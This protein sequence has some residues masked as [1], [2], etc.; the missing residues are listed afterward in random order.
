MI[1]TGD[2]LEMMRDM[3]DNSVD[4][5]VTDPPYG[6]SF[7]G[8]EWD[9]GVPGVPFWTEA[10][11]VL[12]PG[13]YLLAFGGTRTFHRLAVAIEDAGFEIRDCLSWLYGSGF[14][15]SHNIGKAV[16]KIQGNER[17]VLEKIKPAGFKTAAS[18]Y[19]DNKAWSG[20]STKGNSEWEGWGTAL[21]PAWE[22]I[23]MA[24]KPMSEKTVAAN[25]LKWD[26]GG[27]NI[28]SSRVPAYNSEHEQSNI[29]DRKSCQ[30]IGSEENTR[31]RSLCGLRNL[32]EESSQVEVAD[33]T[34]E[35]A[36]YMRS[37]VSVGNDANACQP[38]MAGGNVDRQ[39]DGVSALASP[40]SESSGQGTTSDAVAEGNC[41]ASTGDGAQTGAMANDQ[42]ARSPRQREQVGQSAGESGAAG[43]GKSRQ[44]TS[45]S[46]SAIGET[47]S[48]K[49]A[50]ASRVGK[51][52]SLGRWPANLVLSYPEDEY[53]ADGNLLP[54]PGS[55]EVLAGFPGEGDKSA[56]RFFYCAK[57]SKDERN[58]G[59][60]GM[61]EKMRE[62]N[63]PNSPDDSGRW[64]DHDHGI[65]GANN[66]P[67][68]KPVSLMRWL[69][70][71]VTPPDGVVLDPF[72]GS[73][74]TGVAA[75]REGFRFIGIEMNPEYVLIAELRIAGVR[76]L[77]P[78]TPNIPNHP[79]QPMQMSLIF[80]Q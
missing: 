35:V 56:A 17:K 13:G 39:S 9:H 4:A 46:A 65:R 70:R 18:G 7:M 79:M 42:G 50:S 73:G 52:E 22:P 43:G 6:L 29:P 66:H 24:R 76:G 23:I 2:C 48:G 26:V 20:I 45:P 58:A 27:L 37:G 12:K 55:D 41:R 32:R 1:H 69:V 64:P 11:R 71:M 34:G 74:S 51:G 75:V 21:K 53:D 62:G 40:R 5:V 36:D 28:D 78:E 80:N 77:F 67:T 25:V 44:G 31:G 60:E 14:P 54:N 19:K 61:E 38:K 30:G 68:V 33:R 47:G 16:D 3:A 49:Q 59:L 72:C 8:K 15:K 57:A 63:R 10:L